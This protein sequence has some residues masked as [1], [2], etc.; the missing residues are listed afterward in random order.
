MKQKLF[1]L[2]KSGSTSKKSDGNFYISPSN[3]KFY[4]KNGL[5]L[6]SQSYS[7]NAVYV[8]RLPVS[9]LYQT[10]LVVPKDVPLEDV[11]SIY[12]EEALNDLALD[13]NSEYV[14]RVRKSDS[15]LG[16]SVEYEAFLA[17][18]AKIDE[19]FEGCEAQH[20]DYLIP[21][22]YIFE[23]LFELGHIQ[24]SAI[25]VIFF[26]DSYELFGALYKDGKL[27][28]FRTLSKSLD[29]LTTFF[30]ESSPE[31][32]DKNR[33]LELLKEP[34]PEF[35]SALKRVYGIIAEDIDDFLTYIKRTQR[36]NDFGAICLD[37]ERGLG[38]DIYEYIAGNYGY[39]CRAFEFR[40][41]LAGELIP[42][43]ALRYIDVTH[44]QLWQ[45]FT[46]F[47]K[48]TPL[49][50]RNSARMLLA[51]ALAFVLSMSYPLYNYA[52]SYIVNLETD[53]LKAKNRTYEQEKTRLDMEIESARSELTN[54]ES[55]LKGLLD[56]KSEYERELKGFI[57]YQE[58]KQKSKVII[59]IV[60]FLQ[61]HG[62]YLSSLSFAENNN[63]V[64]FM[65][66]VLSADEDSIAALIN[67]LIKKGGFSV[68]LK[69]I[70]KQ[71]HLYRSSI[72]A[73]LR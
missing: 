11:P 57:D 36:I 23:S 24:K 25:K 72:N 67:T 12:E 14:M 39:E 40:G 26:V 22:P 43:A 49:L 69:E 34:S 38:V 50:K 10:T 9:A 68:S 60:G 2:L 44:G 29:D 63:S 21:T 3:C 5:P 33:L 51:F 47:E 48:P 62:I 7:K 52:S 70:E 55:E 4:G 61:E 16:G 17:P 53:D 27:V 56:T 45:N 54:T 42:C 18:V 37:S 41:V 35:Q 31:E 59:D 6:T 28:F 66:D 65:L 15:D 20:I 13:T 8:S 71:D 58:Y 64:T 30:N 46:V 1:D 19:I 32:I 73:E